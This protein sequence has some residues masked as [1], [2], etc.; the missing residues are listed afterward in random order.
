MNLDVFVTAFHNGFGQP[1]GLDVREVVNQYLNHDTYPL[2]ASF[3]IDA[4]VTVSDYVNI[5]SKE[6]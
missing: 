6:Q 1:N 4:Y 5:T 2:E 3:I